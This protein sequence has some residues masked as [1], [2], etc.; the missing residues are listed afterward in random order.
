MIA[1]RALHAIEQHPFSYFNTINR[2]IMTYLRVSIGEGLLFPLFAFFLRFEITTKILTGLYQ[3][4]HKLNHAKCDRFSNLQSLIGLRQLK[5]LDAKNEQ[6]RKIAEIFDS[7]FKE[8]VLPQKNIPYTK[9]TY[10]AYVINITQPLV[11]NLALIRK[12]LLKKGVDCGIKSEI[13]DNCSF[14]TVN[15]ERCPAAMQVYSSNLQI[16]IYDDMNEK[17]IQYIINN[18]MACITPKETKK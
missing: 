9:R 16:P 7:S 10:H 1:S 18:T 17:E 4:L 15:Y 11:V 8:P 14:Y 13:A 6:R 5:E 2:I 3:A 12:K